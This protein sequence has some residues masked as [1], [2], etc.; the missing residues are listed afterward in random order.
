MHGTTVTTNAVLTRRGAR[1]GLLATKGFRDALALRNGLREAPYDNRLQPPEPLVPRYLRARRRRSASTTRA[2]RS[3]PLAEDDVRAACE[4]LPRRRAS[5]RSRSRSCT[6]RPSP[7]HERRARDL[8]RELLPDAYVTASSDLL[9]QVRYYDRTSTTVLNAYVGPI[10][11]RY[12][13]RA[14]P[15]GSRSSASAACC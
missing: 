3:T 6:R 4:R 15:A 9:P 2:T 14:R 7:A 13:E 8:C 10:I 12:L 1:T 5:R 11:T